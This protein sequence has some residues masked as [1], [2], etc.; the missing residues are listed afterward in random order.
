MGNTEEVLNN[1]QHEY[2]QK[3]IAAVLYNGS[4]KEDEGFST[5]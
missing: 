2:T 1:P 5:I 3:L 4:Y